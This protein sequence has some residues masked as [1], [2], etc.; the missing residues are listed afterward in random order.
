MLIQPAAKCREG[1]QTSSPG[2]NGLG[3]KSIKC[4]HITW[5]NWF[6]THACTHACTHTQARTHTHTHARTHTHTHTHAHTHAHTHQNALQFFTFAPI[7]DPKGTA[8][9]N[10]C[11]KT[12]FPNTLF[13]LPCSE[14]RKRKKDKE[15]PA[16]QEH[17][18][19]KTMFYMLPLTTY[20]VFLRKKSL[21]H[22]II[23]GLV[24]FHNK[25][26]LIVYPCHPRCSCL[27]FFSQSKRKGGFWG[28]HSRIV[29]HIVDFNGDQCVEGL[30]YRFSAASNAVTWSQPRNKGLF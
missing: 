28:K 4:M 1:C 18:M 16:M 19:S 14:R 3:W 23:K 25:N 5:W 12:D 22:R 6:S 8:D 29:I 11:C 24:H 20:V 30:S 27:S 10:N 7:V 13:I 15:N 26:P 9:N 21:K 17:K 2:T